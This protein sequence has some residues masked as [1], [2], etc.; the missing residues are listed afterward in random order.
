M[1]LNSPLP[2]TLPKE[3]AKAAKIFESFVDSGN[4][5]LDG[6]IPRAVL[7]NAR[8][9]A[10][11]T[12]FKAGF[13][14]SAR[15]GTGIVIARLADG[16]WSS[17]SAIGTAGLGFGGQLGAEMTDFLIV[18]NSRSAVKSFMASGSLT[19]GGNMSLALGPLGRNGEALGSLNTSG[20]VAAMYSYSKTRGL[21]GGLSVEG[22]VIVER[23]DANVQAYG[24]QVTAKLLLGGAID[25]PPWAAPLIKTLDACTGLPGNRS[26]I[27]GQPERGYAFATPTSETPPPSQLRKKRKGDK[28][29]FPPA[30]WGESREGGS[31]FSDQIKKAS[32]RGKPELESRDSWEGEGPTT[33]TSQ[34]PTRFKSDFAS[35]AKE[36]RHSRAAASL[37][38]PATV[39]D[40]FDPVS[41]SPSEN[42][43]TSS[44]TRSMSAAP[45]SSYPQ[46]FSSSS[47]NS[48]NSYASMASPALNSMGDALSTSAP[49]IKPKPELTRP[50]LPHEGVARAIAL[51][52]FQAAQ[53][54][55][56]SFSKGD[57]I[58]ITKKSES[59]DDWWT[60]TLNG[61][62]GIFPA[63]FVDVV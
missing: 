16:S 60:G 63:N 18:L 47:L 50:L 55:D 28:P 30:S 8:G 53:S 31:Y 36:Y 49:L 9:F 37:S 56:L 45:Y 1:K 51:Y 20:K 54:G 33:T 27:E 21:F 48:S 39:Y 42:K 13:L 23:Q 29:D 14:F 5:G 43:P 3:C 52:D 6:V 57:V 40:L 10:I 34:F 7:E 24:S 58:I 17:P 35:E 62:R 41:A 46:G 12:I 4:N 38:H 19:L 26:W 44:H 32:L 22:S 15:A 2:Q 59:T 25:P 11:F 61:S